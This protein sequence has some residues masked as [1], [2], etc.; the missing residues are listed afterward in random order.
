LCQL[1]LFL[2]EANNCM[3]TIVNTSHIMPLNADNADNAVLCVPFDTWCVASEWPNTELSWM[4]SRCFPWSV[5]I[6]DGTTFAHSISISANVVCGKAVSYGC[7]Y[8]MPR[9]YLQL[10]TGCA[11]CT[12]R[13]AGGVADSRPELNR[14]SVEGRE[15][16]RRHPHWNPP[17]ARPHARDPEKKENRSWI[18]IRS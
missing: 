4:N 12:C 8:W 9:R 16:A 1:S 10:S 2:L 17:S 5:L 13:D 7:E 3:C 14:C 15:R 6:S 11:P 18:S